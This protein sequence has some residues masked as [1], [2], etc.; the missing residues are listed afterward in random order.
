MRKI[1]SGMI[2]YGK[3]FTY[4]ELAEELN[5]SQSIIRGQINELLKK[6]PDFPLKK[7]KL[8][9]KKRLFTITDYN[10]FEDFKR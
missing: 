4:A 9:N 10:F 8:N 5:V 6:N 3:P 2:E 1:V 7:Q